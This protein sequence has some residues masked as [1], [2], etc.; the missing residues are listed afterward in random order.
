[1][2]PHY[3]PRRLPKFLTLDQTRALLAAPLKA[4]EQEPMKAEPGRPLCVDLAHRD[5]AILETI[6]SAGLRI[7]ELIGLRAADLNWTEQTVLV[8]GKGRKERLIPIGKPALDAIARYW[9]LLPERPT[10]T[11]H[12][13]Q[14]AGGKVRPCNLERRFKCYVTLAGLDP[15]FTP[16]SLRH[17]YATHLLDAGADLRSVQELLGHAHLE[18]TQIYTHVSINHLK[19]A[20]ALFTHNKE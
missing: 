1:M 12:V 9:S 6:Y 16:H 8:R 7:S 2:K 14:T 5:A 3:T 13:F 19:K 15:E 11:D 20:Y 4:L 18:T 17:S 10:G